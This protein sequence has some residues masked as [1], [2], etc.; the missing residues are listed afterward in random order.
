MTSWGNSETA[1]EIA[2][3]RENLERRPSTLSENILIR[4]VSG[5]LLLGWCRTSRGT[6]G[7]DDVPFVFL[8]QASNNMCRGAGVRKVYA[9]RNCMKK[10]F[11]FSVLAQL[12]PV[13]GNNPRTTQCNHN[14]IYFSYKIMRFTETSMWGWVQAWL[15]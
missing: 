4:V 3:E 12:T 5:A 2:K 10:K 14:V 13:F 11:L 6:D 9:R 7:F 15:G 1:K 8:Y